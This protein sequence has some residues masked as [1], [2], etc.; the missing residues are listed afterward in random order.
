MAGKFK[1]LTGKGLLSPLLLTGAKT[2]LLPI[3]NTVLVSAF[4]IAPYI[5]ADG[6]K[7]ELSLVG[8]IMGTFPT[9]PT[10]SA[11]CSFPGYL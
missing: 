5:D 3:L 2:L 6:N 9:A 11:V 4:D 10:V 1:G 7:I 8:F